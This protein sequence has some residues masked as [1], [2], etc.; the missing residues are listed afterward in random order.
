MSRWA[1]GLATALVAGAPLVAAAMMFGL[2]EAG[3]VAISVASIAAFSSAVSAW[4]A[5]RSHRDVRDRI[6]NPNGHGN[7]VQMI[8]RLLSN[9]TSLLSGQT[10]QDARLAGHDSTI[11]AVIAQVSELAA[12]VV[13]LTAIVDQVRTGCVGIR[14]GEDRIESR[15]AEIARHADT[16]RRRSD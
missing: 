1:D 9:Q 11:A 3:T 15:V 14:V 5:N 7:V 2:S 6:G 16:D 8:E 4:L 12:S 10:S 13:E